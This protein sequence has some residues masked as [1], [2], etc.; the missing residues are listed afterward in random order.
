MQS[1]EEA[2]G[3][4]E[5]IAPSSHAPGMGAGTPPRRQ[6]YRIE[7]SF[8]V[9]LRLVRSQSSQWRQSERLAWCR[10][11]KTGPRLRPIHRRTQASL[12]ALYRKNGRKS[13]SMTRETSR[14]GRCAALPSPD[15]QPTLAPN[16]DKNPRGVAGK[17]A[18]GCPLSSPLRTMR[19]GSGAGTPPA[20]TLGPRDMADLKGRL[21]P[22]CEREQALHGVVVAEL[23]AGAARVVT[24]HGCRIHVNRIAATLGRWPAV[25]RGTPDACGVPRR[26]ARARRAGGRPRE[27][28]WRAT[29]CRDD[30][31]SRSP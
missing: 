30:L 31:A 5:R 19:Y 14:R 23:H 15:F 17:Q 4:L 27:A 2:A 29:K 16:G 21:R 3:C 24:Q 13:H 20:R 6:A 18:A 11:T 1:S 10:S 22:R 9:G 25:S 26:I 8:W 28:I 7:S 12:Q